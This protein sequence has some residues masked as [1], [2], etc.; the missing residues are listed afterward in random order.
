MLI[1]GTPPGGVFFLGGLH[2][3]SPEEEDIPSK[4][5]PQTGL[6]AVFSGGVLFLRALYEES[7]QREERPR[8]GGVLWIKVKSPTCEKVCL[9][10]I[11][12]SQ[13]ALQ[14]TIENNIRRI[15]E[16]V[17]L[18]L[19]SRMC[20]FF[21]IPVSFTSTTRQVHFWLLKMS[22]L[23]RFT[24][25]QWARYS[26]SSRKEYTADVWECFPSSQFSNVYLLLIISLRYFWL[27]RMFTLQRFTVF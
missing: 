24:V 26:I 19:H 16:N 23:Q 13:L 9:L 6:G 27:L 12:A 17:Y 5:T 21:P 8:G 2:I 1:Q 14:S 4:T 22:T 20:F 10:L 25:F 3:K 11:L 15:F 7:I 18:F